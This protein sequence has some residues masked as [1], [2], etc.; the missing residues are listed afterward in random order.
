VAAP[1]V[2][3]LMRATVAVLALLVAMLGLAL[4]ASQ[5]QRTSEPQRP[6]EHQGPPRGPQ[7]P[8]P[9]PGPVMATICSN[10]AGW[11]PLLDVVIAV[12]TP[13]QCLV[14]GQGYVGGVALYFN[15]AMY[16]DRP[17]SPYF[18]PH[19]TDAPPPPPVLR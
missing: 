10:D 13:C 9:P 6:S 14:P 1:Q 8:P 4:G 11:C 17:V 18:N 2:G 16:P 15:Y 19:W 12:G 7:P 3:G 5:A